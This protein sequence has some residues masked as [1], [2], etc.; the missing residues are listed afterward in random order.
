MCE[1]K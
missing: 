1:T